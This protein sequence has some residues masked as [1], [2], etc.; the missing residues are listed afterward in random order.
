M[1]DKSVCVN[2]KWGEDEWQEY[3]V[4]IPVIGSKVL[5]WSRRRDDGSWPN[6][7]QDHGKAL[8]KGI[9]REISYLYEEYSAQIFTTYVNVTLEVD[10]A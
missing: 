4:P 1:R 2:F 8:I 6:E 3:D 10:L 5:I 9:V 7:V